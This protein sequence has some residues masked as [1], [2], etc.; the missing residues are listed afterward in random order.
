[1]IGHGNGQETFEVQ[2]DS[3]PQQDAA[4]PCVRAQV[5]DTINFVVGSG[6]SIFRHADFGC[7]K[8]LGALFENNYSSIMNY[9][10]RLTS[11]DLNQK[12]L[13]F[14]SGDPWQCSEGLRMIVLVSTVN[15]RDSYFYDSTAATSYDGS[16]I[17]S[18]SELFSEWKIN[19][20]QYSSSKGGSSLF[21]LLSSSGLSPF[22]LNDRRLRGK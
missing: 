10:Y 22:D 8:A 11:S 3:V 2:W 12:I 4:I 17:D 19:R 13:Y 6:R 1:M 18:P 15:S 16:N 7:G 5:G 9:T 20:D 14:G 21:Q